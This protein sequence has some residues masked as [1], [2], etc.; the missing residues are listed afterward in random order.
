MKI[1]SQAMDRM[2]AGDYRIDDRKITP[3]PRGRIDESMEALIHHFKIFTEGFTVPEGET[4]VAIESPRGELGCYLV[5]DGA[6]KP[7]RMHTRAPSFANLQ[8]LP[9]MMS[10]SL[11]A[12]TVATIA[13]LDPVMGDVDR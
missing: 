8:A 4:Y 13:S 11:I 7:W 5:S 2:P 12:D 10:D 3:P 9:I 6:G 1:V